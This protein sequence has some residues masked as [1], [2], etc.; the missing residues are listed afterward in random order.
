MILLEFLLLYKIS[1]LL[2]LLLLGENVVGLQ[3]LLSIIV[4]GR[5]VDVR[6]FWLF[7]MIIW[8]FKFWVV[9]KFVVGWLVLILLGIYWRCCILLMVLV[10][11]EMGVVGCV[12]IGLQFRLMFKVLGWDMVMGNFCMQLNKLWMISRQFLQFRF[13]KCWERVQFLFLLME[14]IVCC[15]VLCNLIFILFSFLGQMGCLMKSCILGLLGFGMFICQ[16]SVQFR[17]LVMVIV[18]M[19]LVVVVSLLLLL[20]G[21]LKFSFGG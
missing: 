21:Y 14:K 15:L 4:S 18:Q 1:W 9:M 10:V 5:V 16:F 6:Q 17:E 19:F 2:M 8:I 20:L 12:L 13:L 11:R 7:F 3:I